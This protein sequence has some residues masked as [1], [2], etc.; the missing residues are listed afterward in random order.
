MG[1]TH[2]AGLVL[3]ETSLL[4]VYIEKENHGSRTRPYS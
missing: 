1:E 2:P 3:E 4:V